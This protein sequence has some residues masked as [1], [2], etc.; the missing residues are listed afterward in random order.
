MAI[1][2]ITDLDDPRVGDYTMLNDAALRRAH[3][4]DVGICIVEGT[5]ALRHAWRAGIELRSLFLTDARLESMQDVV[6]TVDTPVYVTSQ[7]TMNHVTGFSIHRGVLAAARRPRARPVAELLASARRVA[8]LEDVSDHENLGV[9]FRNAAGL[10]VDAV[11]LSPRSC[12]PL[13]RRAIRVSMGH[14]L[15]IPFARLAP[16]PDA[17]DALRAAEFVRVALTPAGTVE[18]ADAGLAGC[19]RVALLFGAEGP[20]LTDAAMA[21]VD[22]AARIRMAGGVD[23]LNLASA[24]AIAF[25]AS[26]SKRISRP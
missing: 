21:K 3:E 16:W 15:T 11:L 10:D 13:Y 25:Y 9:L 2:R 12:D 1:V 19:E 5:H 7:A 4:D 26:R 6:D 22:V 14:T 20:G 23:S 24:A 18:L 17:L 8:V